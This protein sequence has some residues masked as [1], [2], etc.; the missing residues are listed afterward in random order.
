MYCG[1][2]WRE[3]W[4]E[5]KIRGGSDGTGF[6]P[7]EGFEGDHRLVHDSPRYDGEPLPSLPGMCAGGPKALLDLSGLSESWSS[8]LLTLDGWWI[9]NGDPVHG[10]CEGADGCSHLRNGR[11]YAEDPVGYL[12]SLAPETVL[13][14]LLCH[15]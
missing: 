6:F 4:D 11:W 5:W 10:A 7:L 1:S 8:D 2:E 3:I 13:V 12:A 9:E 15:G 14:K